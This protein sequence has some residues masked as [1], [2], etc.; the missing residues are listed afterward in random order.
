MLPI[1]GL[2]PSII[3]DWWSQHSTMLISNLGDFAAEMLGTGT[4]SDS[5]TRSPGK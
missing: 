1:L 4:D 2:D 5:A 3:A